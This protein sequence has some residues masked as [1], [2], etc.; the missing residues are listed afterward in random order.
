MNTT[1][2][3]HTGAVSSAIGLFVLS[4]V[5]FSARPG[6]ADPPGANVVYPVSLKARLAHLRSRLDALAG[7]EDLLDTLHFA[8]FDRPYAR[9]TL[10]VLHKTVSVL[11][12]EARLRERGN[13]AMRDETVSRML[14]W[15]DGAVD[16]VITSEVEADFR[17]HRTGVTQAIL[18]SASTTPA[19]FSF[20]DRASSTRCSHSFGDLDL[21]AAMGL[22]VYTRLNGESGSADAARLRGER[23]NTLGIATIFLAAS[24]PAKASRSASAHALTVKGA[25][26]RQLHTDAATTEEVPGHSLALIDPP[27][28]ES[29][30]SSLARRA[31]ARGCTGRNRYVADVWNAPV[32]PGQVDDV[33]VT[34]AAMWVHAVD[35]QTLGLVRG[36]R[37]LRDGS[38][39]PYPSRL[40]HPE[41]TET[42]ALTALDLL[43]LGPYITPLRSR[44]SL[45]LALQDDALDSD[46]DNAWAGWIEPVF[47]ALYQRQLSFD[48]VSENTFSRELHQR[49]DVV[50]TLRRADAS[51]LS[52]FLI[53]LERKLA[54]ESAYAS[55]VTA[56]ELDGRLA[57]NVFI[58]TGRTPQG[59]LCFAVANLCPQIR[60]LRLEGIESRPARDVI[61]AELIHDPAQ[62]LSMSPW[63]VRVL[64]PAR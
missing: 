23:A 36:W 21:V 26:L 59:G 39:N 38:A 50:T 51:E 12:R 1:H 45:V 37:D 58:R 62:G 9:A 35:G 47:D 49:Y 8:W 46:D 7:N 29:W 52:S 31:L 33:A 41:Q 54:G 20:V 63:Q 30:A 32:A 16:R 22:R 2:V 10:A 19:L 34:A 18:G 14:T 42:I 13:G 28:G 53:S 64:W 40:T 24:T 55:R 15:A 17:P 25:S 11:D 5:C 56:N 6:L 4:L 57:A 61:S 60:E 3:R 43:Q 48:L 44:P 27:F